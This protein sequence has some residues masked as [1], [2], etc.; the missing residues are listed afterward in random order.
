[1]LIDAE[2]DDLKAFIM[3]EQMKGSEMKGK[4]EYGTSVYNRKL[5]KREN[6]MA[7]SAAAAD[8]RTG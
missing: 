8:G 6:R 4:I 1:M 7:V 2:V 3:W 5:G